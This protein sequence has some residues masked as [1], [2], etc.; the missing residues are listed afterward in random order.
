MANYQVSTN[1]QDTKK[2]L[3]WRGFC[4]PALQDQIRMS[5]RRLKQIRC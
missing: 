5:K 3:Q 2:P 1:P 4:N